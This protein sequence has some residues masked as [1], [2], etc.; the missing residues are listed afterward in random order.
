[1]KKYLYAGIIVVFLIVCAIIIN[2]K[3]NASTP[4]VE[5]TETVPTSIVQTEE[6][7]VQETVDWGVWSKEIEDDP[8]EETKETVVN[9]TVE[10]TVPTAPPTAPMGADLDFSSETPEE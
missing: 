1:M 3:S 10:T 5:T 6:N 2:W 4:Q 7:V 8:E 9:E